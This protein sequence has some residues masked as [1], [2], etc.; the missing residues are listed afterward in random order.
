V[1]SFAA[2]G[3][4]LSVGCPHPVHG[5]VELSGLPAFDERWRDVP[6]AVRRYRSWMT[7]PR[8]AFLRLDPTGTCHMDFGPAGQVVWRQS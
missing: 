6:D 7:E 4:W 3:S 5:F 1:A 8:Y 2:D